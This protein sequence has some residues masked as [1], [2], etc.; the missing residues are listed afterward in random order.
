VVYQYVSPPS[1]TSDFRSL[2]VGEWF[3]VGLAGFACLKVDCDQ[4]FDTGSNRVLTVDDYD[5]ISIIS[6]AGTMTLWHNN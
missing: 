5:I 1:G 6:L 2:K 3:Q 4:Y